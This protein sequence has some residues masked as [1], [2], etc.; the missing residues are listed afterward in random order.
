MSPSASSVRVH[1]SSR[2]IRID[3]CVDPEGATSRMC[4]MYLQR[5]GASEHGPREGEETR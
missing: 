4:L 3:D 5:K 1:R 2:G